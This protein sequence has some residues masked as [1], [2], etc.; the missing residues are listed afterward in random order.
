MTPILHT[1]E[2]VAYFLKTSGDAYSNG[3]AFK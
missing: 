2:C 3:V 1:P